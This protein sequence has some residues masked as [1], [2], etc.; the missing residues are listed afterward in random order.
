MARRGPST[1]SDPVREF[2][3]WIGR[4]VVTHPE[5][6]ELLGRNLIEPIVGG[7]ALHEHWH[8]VS[9]L[10]GQSLNI[11]DEQRG[12]WHQTWVSETGMLLQLDGGMRD[13]S[14]ELQGGDPLQRIR[15]TPG[16]DGEVLQHWEEST[17]GGT[18]WTTLF[19]GLYRPQSQS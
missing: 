12:Q 1:S 6:G 4:W 3:F 17:D 14:M 5:T 2:D 9:G 19:E 18:S 16:A 8:G 13:G 11:F 10:Q 7:R 15:W